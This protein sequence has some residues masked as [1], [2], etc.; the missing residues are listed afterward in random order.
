MFLQYH[1]LLQIDEAAAKVLQWS[2]E[3]RTTNPG[4]HEFWSSP[5]IETSSEK[6]KWLETSLWVGQGYFVV[7]DQGSAVAY[8]I[9][10]ALN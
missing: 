3:A 5:I 7:D 8:E 6:Y 1:G 2:P 9:Y 10:R 4:D